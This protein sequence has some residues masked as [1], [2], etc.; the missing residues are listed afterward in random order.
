M[1]TATADVQYPRAR[2][3]HVW[4]LL[5]GVRQV[6]RLQR[7]F[8]QA[9]GSELGFQRGG[10]ISQVDV[11]RRGFRPRIKSSKAEDSPL[12]AC[13][14]PALTVSTKQRLGWVWW[15]MPLIPELGKQR[16]EN[17]CKFKAN[18]FFISSSKDNQD[19][20]ERPSQ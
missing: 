1:L 4:K 18:Q 17:S 13:A 15:R 10:R 3:Q 2:V 19:Y 16:Q 20:I 12:C 14:S 7:L 5:Q 9:M 6:E 8:L 11:R